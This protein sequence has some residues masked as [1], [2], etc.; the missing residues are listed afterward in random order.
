MVRKPRQVDLGPMYLPLGEE[1]GLAAER[2]GL[3]DD[4]DRFAALLDA[5]PRSEGRRSSQTTA[6]QDDGASVSDLADHI[7]S[8]WER[9]P[10]G[11]DTEVRVIPGKDVAPH[12]TLRLQMRAGTLHV[13]IHCDAS[14]NP[15]WFIPRLPSL[16][17]DLGSRLQRP[18]S[19]GLFG[20]Q[21]DRIGHF[22]GAEGRA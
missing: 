1:D 22:E 8:M 15:A 17:R 19:V 5:A 21:G 2:A 4:A 9:D 7:H 16:G 6:S 12:T 3:A 20:P 13:D 10:S 14:A 11:T 18:I